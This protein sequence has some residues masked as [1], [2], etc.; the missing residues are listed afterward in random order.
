MKYSELLEILYGKDYAKILD[1]INQAE[2]VEEH[3]KPVEEYGV[4]HTGFSFVTQNNVKMELLFNNGIIKKILRQV[5]NVYFPVP[6]INGLAVLKGNRNKRHFSRYLNRI[7]TQIEKNENGYELMNHEIRFVDAIVKFTPYIN[8]ISSRIKGITEIIVSE[9]YWEDDKIINSFKIIENSKTIKEFPLQRI[10]DKVVFFNGTSFEK[11]LSDDESIQAKKNWKDEEYGEAEDA[12]DA[13]E[14]EFEDAFNTD[15]PIDF[16]E[17]YG[18]YSGT[19]AQDN[20][21]LSDNF[22][23]DVLDGH[24][25]AYWNID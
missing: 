23:D 20:E 17:S 3:S 16:K 7:D 14:L 13:A 2:C 18:K 24:P 21:G 5:Q 6:Q 1:V 25:E 12:E 8:G 11:Y 10:L 15:A 9:S 4:V 22:I 19:W